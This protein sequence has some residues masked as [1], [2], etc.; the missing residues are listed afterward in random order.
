MNKNMQQSSQNGGDYNPQVVVNNEKTESV[1]LDAVLDHFLNQLTKVEFGDSP[2]LRTIVVKASEELQIKALKTGF[3]AKSTSTGDYI[4]N[5]KYYEKTLEDKLANFLKDCLLKMEAGEI[6]SKHYKT[7][8]DMVKQFRSTFYAPVL[9]PR[10]N[11]INL[12]NGVLNVKTMTLE[13][14]NP[15]YDM[16]YILGYSFDKDAKC[17]M[18]NKYLERVL[19]SIESQ[20]ALQ[21]Y[22]AY[23][24][25]DKKLEKVAFLYGG[26]ANGKSVC[27]DVVRHCYGVN[28]VTSYSLESLCRSDGQ[29]IPR[30]IEAI[31]NICSD[32]SNKAINSEV[33]KLL[34][35]KEP[36]SGKELYKN[37]VIISDYASLL[38][39][40]N[41]M[42]ATTD[43]SNGYF[44]RLLIIPFLVEIPEG[45]RDVDLAKKIIANELS[46][47]LNWI[48]E[49]MIRLIVNERFT[50]SE[51]MKKAMINF[52]TESD[53]VLMF[54][55]E[56]GYRQDLDRKEQLKDLYMEYSCY[57][58][59]SGFSKVSKRKF[60]DRLKNVGFQVE[61]S[62]GGNMYVFISR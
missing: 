6:I 2:K 59:E 45:E 37:P 40:T 52:R 47:V 34:A 60:S 25:T 55:E 30:I 57:C 10:K 32:I 62:T 28:N 42:P 58:F 61:K 9:N 17:P 22:L 26:G 23:P 46:G 54:I 12:W 7:L 14:H 31:M 13:N 36:I 16:N 43:Y 44:R 19:P 4:W 50:E 53:S 18:W 1:S 8:E 11:V 49:G 24:F 48:L 21:E 39:S 5:G 41:E 33:F 56:K 27:L 38:F 3:Y 35:S 20:M 29:Y 15:C 51:E